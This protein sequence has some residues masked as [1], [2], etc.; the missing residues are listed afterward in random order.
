MIKVLV[1]GDHHLV[2]TSIAK[3]IDSHVDIQVIGE[4]ASSENTLPLVRKLCPDIVLMDL[5]MPSIGGLSITRK[6]IRSMPH[7]QIIALTLSPQP[8]FTQRLMDVGAAGCISS[9]TE[10]SELIRA[11]RSVSA[12]QRYLSPDVAQQ[13]ALAKVVRHTNPFDHLTQRELEVAVMIINCHKV[14]EIAECLF[15]SPKTVN[16]YRYRAF[17]KLD[18]HTDV[19]LTHLGLRYG[20][21]EGY[22]A[23]VPFGCT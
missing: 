5:R 20:W 12:G 8:A 6:V 15:V 7:V 2:R 1:A 23:T 9:V 16:T 21:V 11:I 18:V 17:E 14:K 4:S 22:S 19:E 10:V 13:I 3:V